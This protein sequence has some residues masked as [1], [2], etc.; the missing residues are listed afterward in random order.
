MG[1]DLFFFKKKN[2]VLEEVDKILGLE[3]AEPSDDHFISTSL[4]ITISEDIEALHIYYQSYIG[5]TGESRLGMNYINYCLSMYNNNHIALEI[6]YHRRNNSKA[7]A[8]ELISIIRILFE[9]GF[10]CFDPQ[11]SGVLTQP[12]DFFSVFLTSL[13]ETERILKKS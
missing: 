7:L 6:P 5:K 4:L 2:L 1:H 8:E 11:V 12:E 13:I 9:R 10:S 3:K